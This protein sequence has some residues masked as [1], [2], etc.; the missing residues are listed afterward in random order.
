MTRIL[1]LLKASSK[2]CLTLITGGL[3]G[4]GITAANAPPWLSYPT[5]PIPPA[6][7]TVV[8][9]EKIPLLVDRCNTTGKA[10]TYKT[11]RR[12]IN[13]SPSSKQKIPD[14]ILESR[15]V[16]IKLDVIESHQP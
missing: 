9:G 14:V 3:I 6:K 7:Y 16:D 5:L 15:E 1:Q 12:L 2:F 11:T 8:A 4:F 10:Q 13:V